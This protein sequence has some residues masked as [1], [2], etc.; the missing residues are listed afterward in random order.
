M[1]RRAG[2]RSPHRDHDPKR[3]PSPQ[4][5]P[6]SPLVALAPARPGLASGSGMSVRGSVASA[7]GGAW[8]DATRAGEAAQ[9]PIHGASSRPKPRACACARDPPRPSW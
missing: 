7:S 3:R 9:Q 1:G 2:S 6:P 4:L 8:E 5:V